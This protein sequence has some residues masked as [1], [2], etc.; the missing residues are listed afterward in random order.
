VQELVAGLVRGHQVPVG[1]IAAA[2]DGSD[3]VDV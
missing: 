1:V 3:V 2:A